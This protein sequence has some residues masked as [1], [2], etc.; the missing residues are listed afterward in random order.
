[1]KIEVKEISKRFGATLALDTVSLT[2]ESGEIHTL[3]GEN[4]AGK[5]TLGKII[6]GVYQM[7]SGTIFIDDVAAQYN[8]SYEALQRGITIIAQE[9]A[10][11][12]GRTVIENVFLGIEDVNGLFV[13]RKKLRQRFTDLVKSS[14]I[15]ID[16]DAIVGHL[17]IGDQQKVEIL[18]ALARDSSTIV[19]DEPT[20][21]LSADEIATLKS[22]IKNLKQKG[23]TIIFVSHFL[24]DVLEISDKIS[25]MRDGRLVR[26][27]TPAQESHNSLVEAMTGTSFGDAYPK[28]KFT[29]ANSEVVL[30]VQGLSSRSRFKNISFEIKAGEILGIAGLV[31]SGRTEL[32]R[33]IFGVDEFETG[34]VAYKGAKLNR[35]S[36]AL[37][38]SKGIGFLP[39]SRK[40]QGIIP[41]RSLSE[42]IS[43]PHLRSL[44]K[45][46]WINKAAERALVDKF[47]AICGLKAASTQVHISSLSGG[48]QQKALFARSLAGEPQLFIADE[49]TRGVDV[50]SKRVIY[51][52]LVEQANAGMAV[53]VVSSELDEVVG[54]THRVLVMREGEIV[55]EL[56]G[57][58]VTENSVLAA[59]FSGTVEDF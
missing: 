45:L 38:I 8:S 26:T 5:S 7:D 10:L 20:A 11:V 29:P 43:L 39:E 54:L 15:D 22:L 50:G 47:F 19:M 57:D 16:G 12:P 25:I 59:A 34:T 48:N 9:L 17:R 14:G 23:H 46:G 35:F 58:E 51:D 1:V 42:N 36:P 21:R 41:H 27:S 6:A 2:V 37:S 56:A 18:R 13:A 52:L 55:K 31:G 28:K 3:V 30:K 49:P 44:S 32:V 4:G 53:L 33:A 40:E 24:N